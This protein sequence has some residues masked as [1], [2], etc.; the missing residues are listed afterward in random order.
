MLF[1]TILADPPWQYRS[2]STGGSMTSGSANK[3]PVMSLEELCAMR[4]AIDRIRD[5]N[6]SCLF[7]WATVPMLLEAFE[8]MKAWGYKYKTMITWHKLLPKGKLGLGYWFRG[9]VELLLFGIHRRVPAFRSRLRNHIESV[10]PGHS[11][12]PKEVYALIEAAGAP[13]PRIELFAAE[14]RIGWNC[15]GLEVRG[16]DRY[17]NVLEI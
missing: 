9:E 8:V 12:K 11:K 4:S 1:K 17:Y 15:W 13:E 14:E 6:G 10:S 16:C 5:P 3:Y 7:L 2:R